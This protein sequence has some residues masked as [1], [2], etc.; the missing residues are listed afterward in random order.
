MYSDKSSMSPIFQRWT[1]PS[2]HLTQTGKHFCHMTKAGFKFSFSF[3]IYLIYLF[4]PFFPG[5]W[6]LIVDEC[7]S[8]PLKSRSQVAWQLFNRTETIISLL[9]SPSHDFISVEG[10]STQDSDL[11]QARS[12]YTVYLSKPTCL[13]ACCSLSSPL[14]SSLALAC[15][16]LF[17][18]SSW[19]RR[20]FRCV[21]A[22]L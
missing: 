5:P 6:T 19:D 7:A 11:P 18:L 20:W 4:S 1:H 14:S 22:A 9:Q 10:D 16:S 13:F 2:C 17:L 3:L 15:D 12:K 8:G 21:G